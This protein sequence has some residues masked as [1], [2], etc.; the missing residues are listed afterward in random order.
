MCAR[1]A[2]LFVQHCAIP[3]GVCRITNQTAASSPRRLTCSGLVTCEGCRIHAAPPPRVCRFGTQRGSCTCV[4]PCHQS[5]YHHCTCLAF[6]LAPEPP[7]Q[8]AATARWA[9]TYT[10]WWPPAE[11]GGGTWLCPGQMTQASWIA[12]PWR[13]H[14]L[15]VDLLCWGAVTT[16]R[17]VCCGPW[18][19]P[20]SDRQRP[21]RCSVLR[22]HCSRAV[23]RLD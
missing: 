1:P 2:A 10:L 6:L 13:G 8:G 9:H 22:G 18:H 16:V 3:T 11:G 19:L 15:A 4:P 14:T 12:A 23:A 20:S 21:L 17:V 7:P 5:L